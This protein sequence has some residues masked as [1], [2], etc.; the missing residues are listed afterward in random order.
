MQKEI[1]L[2]NRKQ[3]LGHGFLNKGI[4]PFNAGCS[5]VFDIFG[6]QKG[7]DI[8]AFRENWLRRKTRNS[9]EY[10]FLTTT[11]DLN[12]AFNQYGKEIR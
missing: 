11:S 1:E 5:S 3:G 7:F 6:T 8:D 2:M 4:N 9:I 12:F 10:D